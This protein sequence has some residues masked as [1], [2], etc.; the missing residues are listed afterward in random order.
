VRQFGQPIYYW[1]NFPPHE[2]IVSLRF[3]ID[4]GEQEA[5]TVP[6]EALEN[7]DIDWVHRAVRVLGKI[8][9]ARAV[10]PL[11]ATVDR[12]AK[13]VQGTYKMTQDTR[14]PCNPGDVV[15][16][17][18][19]ALGKLADTRAV[20][21]LITVLGEPDFIIS[22]AAARALGDLGDPRA[23]EPLVA[24][25]GRALSQRRTATRD[26]DIAVKAMIN[27]LG[28]IGDSAAVEPLLGMLDHAKPRVIIWVAEA[29]GKIGDVRAAE[30]L[31]SLLLGNAPWLAG[32]RG[33]VTGRSALMTVAA[34]LGRLGDSRLV[35]P[36]IDALDRQ[37]DVDV[38][39]SALVLGRLGDRRAVEPLIAVL[40]GPRDTE[41]R[42]E[43]ATALGRLGDSRAVDPLIDALTGERHQSKDD[44]LRDEIVTA[45]GAL[46]D[47]RAVAPLVTVLDESPRNVMAALGDLG[48]PR[49]VPPLITYLNGDNLYDRADAA[50]ALGRIGGPESG[51]ALLESIHTDPRLRDS[52]V[53]ALENTLR[54]NDRTPNAEVLEKILE[55]PDNLD[56]PPWTFDDPTSTVTL[57]SLKDLAAAELNRHS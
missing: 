53:P 50:K 34:A 18:V 23:A 16:S 38:R 30:R 29:L 37:Y 6:L 8:G 5:L 4:R 14:Q 52:T 35:E 3:R 43:A 40:R 7:D 33:P 26:S 48:D 11:I 39:A 55:L 17:G 25:L 27:A 28:K 10:E 1:T 2:L 22:A 54:N 31:S 57:G 24:G 13:S 46:G 41:V 12:H 44:L 45:L 15:F 36:L 42:G 47:R 32:E 9:D 49:A 19:Q 56:V 21:V 20:P 51:A